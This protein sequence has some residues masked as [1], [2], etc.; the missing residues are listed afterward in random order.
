MQRY[1]N[2]ID[3][4]DSKDIETDRVLTVVVDNG[5]AVTFQVADVFLYMIENKLK[6]EL[7]FIEHQI[8][9]NQITNNSIESTLKHLMFDVS[10]ANNFIAWKRSL[11]TPYKVEAIFN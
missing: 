6:S 2:I 3:T 1:Q 4:L 5:G 9:K 11:V 10:V 8:N 7:D